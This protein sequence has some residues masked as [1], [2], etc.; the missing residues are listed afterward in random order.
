MTMI[1]MMM[2]MQN[3]HSAKHKYNEHISDESSFLF[4]V[5]KV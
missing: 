5:L 4:V 1:N 2:M 3:I